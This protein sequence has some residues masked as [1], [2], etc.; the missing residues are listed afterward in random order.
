[1]AST[2]F[3][4]QYSKKKEQTMLQVIYIDRI[5][6]CVYVIYTLIL[7]ILFFF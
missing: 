3:E 4:L 5:T 1:M 6:L 7:L 2:D